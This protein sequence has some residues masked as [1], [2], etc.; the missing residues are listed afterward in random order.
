MASSLVFVYNADSGL[1]NALL[2]TGRR[3]L[4]P[5]SYPCSLCKVTYGP[6][7]M[8]TEWKQFIQSLPCT[9]EFLHKDELPQAYSAVCLEFPCVLLNDTQSTRVVLSAADFK[10]IK[11][12]ESLKKLITSKVY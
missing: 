7:G 2:D 5:Q 1:A 10:H 12:L 11:D 4:S 8:K 9:V 6:F 3:V